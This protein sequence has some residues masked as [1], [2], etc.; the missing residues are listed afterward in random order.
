[1]Q[2]PRRLLTF[3]WFLARPY[4]YGEFVR[5]LIRY[6]GRNKEL[7]RTQAEEAEGWC[8]ARA[9][10]TAQALSL[11][12]GLQHSTFWADHDARLKAARRRAAACPV[13]MGGAGNLEL[14][15]EISTATNATR[16]IE[17][18]VALGWSTLALL[19]SLSRGGN[20]KLVST[21]MPYP[22]EQSEQYVGCVVPSDLSSQWILLRGP[23]RKVLP[24]ALSMLPAI[25]LCHYDSDKSYKGRRWA[26]PLLWAALRPG[27]ILISDDVGDNFG[28]RDFS[29]SVQG[30]PIIVAMSKTI[31]TKYVG[32]LVKSAD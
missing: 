21:D 27:G 18:G 10:D 15:Y 19:L 11:L 22:K 2:L 20:G 4:M 26:Y 1:M 32:I 17:T 3:R 7:A 31:G 29:V 25:D 5:Q 9:I 12:C 24:V 16:V 8:S 30:E 14:L 6:S 13:R 23:D 28:F